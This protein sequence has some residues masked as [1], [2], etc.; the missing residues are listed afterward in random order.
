VLYVSGQLTGRGSVWKRRADGSAPAE[1]VW[2]APKGTIAEASVS[3]DGQWLIYRLNGDS[4]SRDIY[5]IRL[6]RDTTPIPLLTGRF[7]E[8][9]AALSPDGKWLAYASDES[10]RDEV[11]VRPFP[12]TAAGRWQVST[13]GGFAARWSHSGRELFYEAPTGD[14]MAMPVTS[15]PTFNPG[16]PQRLFPLGSGLVPSSIV[17]YYDLTPDDRR[18]VMV[19]LAAVNQAPG[20]GQVVIVDNWFEELGRKMQSAR[21]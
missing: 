8:Q 21:K 17:P 6:G 12:N 1:P 16:A 18:F 2:Q 10:G 19:R 5:A 15:G 3:H 20:A 4:G 13:T 9:G 14:L 7:A 11:Y